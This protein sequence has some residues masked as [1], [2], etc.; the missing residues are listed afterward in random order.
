M[1]FLE[2]YGPFG[3]LEKNSSEKWVS[4]RGKLTKNIKVF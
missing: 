1:E 3:G 2:S 4:A